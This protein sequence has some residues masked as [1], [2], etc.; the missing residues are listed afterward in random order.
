[1]LRQALVDDFGPLD[2]GHSFQHRLHA[3]GERPPQSQDHCIVP[4]GPGL[5]LGRRAVG[6]HFALGDDHGACTHRVDF[7]QYVRGQDNGLVPCHGPDEPAH[8]MF[9]VGIEPVGGFVENQHGRIVHN[10][11]SQAHPPLE[12][13]GEGVNRLM[14]HPLE[15]HFFHGFCH[16]AIQLRA[17]KP[18]HFGNEHQKTQR[19]HLSIGRG[20]FGQVPQAFFGFERLLLYI[21]AVDLGSAPGRSQKTRNHFHGRG[22]SRAVGP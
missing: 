15:I 5:Q 4:A 7:F 9:L 18:A 11:L 2:P 10:G 6:D 16:P 19:C 17:T 1:M 22:F 20:P 12:S 13:L 8:F 14:R 21:E 3:I